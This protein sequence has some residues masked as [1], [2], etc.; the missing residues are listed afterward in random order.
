MRSDRITEQYTVARAH[1]D[2]IVGSCFSREPK[3]VD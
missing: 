1:P 2:A 3:K